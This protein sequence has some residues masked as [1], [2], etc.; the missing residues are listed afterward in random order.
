MLKNTAI[1]SDQ[2]TSFYC[3]S[4]LPNHI[5]IDEFKANCDG[6]K[7]L[8]HVFDL[9]TKKLLPFLNLENMMLLLIFL[10]ILQTKSCRI[11]IPLRIFY[12]TPYFYLEH[13]VYFYN[14]LKKM[15]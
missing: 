5:S 10:I 11:L 15:R 6:S 9:D 12:I 7:Y 4:C 8:F 14:F 3:I 1:T 2:V 13:L